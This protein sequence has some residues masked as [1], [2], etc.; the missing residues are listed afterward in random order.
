MSSRNQDLN[1]YGIGS[2]LN[3][4]ILR[5]PKNFSSEVEIMLLV[6][7]TRSDIRGEIAR[8][9][10]YMSYVPENSRQLRIR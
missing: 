3:L 10:M 2:K 1:K 5:R 4:E 6:V 9:Y 8:T 7:E